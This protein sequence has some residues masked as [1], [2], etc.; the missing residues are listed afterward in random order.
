M[1]YQLLHFVNKKSFITRKRK[2]IRTLSAVGEFR[3]AYRIRSIYWY[4]FRLRTIFSYWVSTKYTSS[5]KSYLKRHKNKLSHYMLFRVRKLVLMKDHELI[6][7]DISWEKMFYQLLHFV[8]KKS[9][10]TRKRKEIRTLSAVGEFRN[11]FRI[12][13]IYWYTFR[14]RTIFSYWVSTKYTSS[15]KS[16]LK[17][18]KNKLSHYM[19]LVKYVNRTP[20]KSVCFI[21]LWTEL[22]Q[23]V[24][25]PRNRS[26]STT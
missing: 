1:F 14:L 26:I 16:Y 3:N 5:A 17:R 15:A 21:S 9:F 8:N 6:R 7:L 12:R 22:W 13:S 10:I 23:N 19:L 25:V 20:C 4:T 24:L 11:A 18:H 2:E